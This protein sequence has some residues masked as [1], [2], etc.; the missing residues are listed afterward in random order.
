[1]ESCHIKELLD[2]LSC[3]VGNLFEFRRYTRFLIQNSFMTANIKSLSFPIHPVV[4]R[5]Y[6]Y[7]SHKIRISMVWLAIR[8]V[9]FAVLAKDDVNYTLLQ[10]NFLP[11]YNRIYS[12]LH[13]TILKNMHKVFELSQTEAS[14]WLPLLYSDQSMMAEAET[15]YLHILAGKEKSWRLNYR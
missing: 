13:Q 5:W 11:Q 4:Y 2:W 9:A 15:M 3:Y 8:V 1:M 7:S 12:L 6:F 10:R 14:A